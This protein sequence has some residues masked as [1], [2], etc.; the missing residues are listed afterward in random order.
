MPN[1]EIHKS[2]Y[3]NNKLF[4]SN[5]SK[6]D[7]SIDW[8][9]TVI[10]YCAVHYIESLLVKCFDDMT[11]KGV[12]KPKFNGHSRT[13]DDRRT[14]LEMTNEFDFGSKYAI[15]YDRLEA[16]SRKARYDQ[17]NPNIKVLNS[18]LKHLKTIEDLTS[19]TIK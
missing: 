7:N 13:H 16:E 2:K 11:R 8:Q 14:M 1:F 18:A 15:A 9:I 12:Y 4:L 3:N 17:F 5:I 10:F 19:L 6:I